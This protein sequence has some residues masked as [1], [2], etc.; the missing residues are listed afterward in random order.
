MPFTDHKLETFTRKI[1]DLPDEPKLLPNELKAYFDSS[2]EE[3][4]QAHNDLCTSLD[5]IQA[6]MVHFTMTA[7]V[8]EENVQDA[9][10]NVQEQ[11]TDAIM[12]N[13]PS[14]SV[15]GDKLAQDVRDRFTAIETAATTEASTRASADSTEAA[16][17]A[18]AD[19]NLQNQINNL[20]ANKCEVY[21]GSYTGNGAAEQ[22]I[23][24]GFAP[25]AVL[26]LYRGFTL[27]SYEVHGGLAFNNLP[28]KSGN[29]NCISLDSTGFTAYYSEGYTHL[30]KNSYYFC[31][32]AFK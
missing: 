11:L 30:N 19:A 22:H 31:Y 29:I 13:I 5:E 16:T 2:P 26:I 3:L 10:E 15:T 17:R 28:L 25:K 32:L 12:G 21:F 4:R 24:L 27:G 6:S 18:S 23:N 7:G 20:S 9:I 14:G 1:S 8:P